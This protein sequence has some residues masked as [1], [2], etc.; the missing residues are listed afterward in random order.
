MYNQH[1]TNNHAYQPN[2][3]LYMSTVPQM[4]YMQEINSLGIPEQVALQIH[5]ELCMVLQSK[6]NQSTVRAAMFN[7]YA[8]NGYNNQSYQHL[9]GSAL[10]YFAAASRQNVPISKIVDD[11]IK[12][13]MPVFVDGDYNLAQTLTPDQVSGIQQM[14]QLRD[15]IAMTIRQMM[16]GGQ[17]QPHMHSGYQQPQ[18]YGQM[19]SGNHM[20]NPH[21]H[22]GT[23]NYGNQR[24]SGQ[25]PQ[26]NQMHHHGVSMSQRPNMQGMVYQQHGNNRMG[27]GTYTN[28]SQFEPRGTRT[29]QNN[30][31]SDTNQEF[32]T[33]PKMESKRPYNV[34]L[35]TT[36]MKGRSSSMN[37][38]DSTTQKIS[39]HFARQDVH[40]TTAHVSKD[41]VFRLRGHQPFVRPDQVAVKEN[42]EWVV[43]EKD[44]EMNYEDHEFDP[45]MVK[46]SKSSKVGPKVAP[47]ADWSAV[48]A[49]STVGEEDT[50]ETTKE[51]K[52][53]QSVFVSDEILSNTLNEAVVKTAQ[54]LTKKG[55][56]HI[57]D[58]VVE[59]YPTL[60]TPIL[61]SSKDEG[62]L[63]KLAGADSM[64]SFIDTLTE[65]AESMTPVAFYYITDVV[66]AAVNRR[67]AAGLNSDI[68]ITN[69][70][71]DYED[72]L[73]TLN[74]DG[75][76]PAIIDRWKSNVLRAMKDQIKI[77]TSVTGVVTLA[78][79]TS[80]T[81]LPWSSDDINIA[82]CDDSVE[83]G[84]EGYG[85]LHVDVDESFY[86]ACHRIYA[87]TSDGGKSVS[88]RYILTADNVLLEL[89]TS[90]FSS[91][92][93]SALVLSKVKCTY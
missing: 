92:A 89:H 61:A 66:T 13:Q 53:T 27:M 55:I 14:R 54:Y 9:F 4:P 10:E 56:K 37:Y 51:L 62:V 19:H 30:N 82:L 86:A 35:D 15:Q 78:S 34:S 90:D 33:P 42:G 91:T 63:K 21:Y 12:A 3:N 29:T 18:S 28:S 26:Q 70:L 44:N 88:R 58:R 11:T 65:G 84:V 24:Y 79:N 36:E 25:Y 80:L 38:V 5:S 72:L 41:P 73:V 47:K 39:E 7:A 52:K 67:L 74:E 8:Q 23:P 76:S 32:K 77:H 20:H 68:T 17:P 71:E 40:Q 69:V 60:L 45:G 2:Q 1:G 93:N 75:Y 46:L 31:S 85:A 16:G 49:A 50:E 43:Y 87:R 6:A 22:S 83:G 48:C 59:S 57:T 64:V 81:Q